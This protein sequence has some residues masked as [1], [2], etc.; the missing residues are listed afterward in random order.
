MSSFDAISTALFTSG[1]QIDDEKQRT[2]SEIFLNKKNNQ[3]ER[4][5]KAQS[6]VEEQWQ[7]SLLVAGERDRCEGEKH[8]EFCSETF[9]F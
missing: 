9:L 6:D 2:M 3:Q 4:E 5:R 7:K 1:E 8:V